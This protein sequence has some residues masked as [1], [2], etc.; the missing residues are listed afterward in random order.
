[1]IEMYSFGKIIV[2]GVRYS[3]DI[4]IIQKTVVPEWWRKNGHWVVPEDIIDIIDAEPEIIILGTGSPGMMKPG[5]DLIRLLRT[6]KIEL[7]KAPTAE[8]VTLFNR[9]TEEKKNIAA[10]FHLTC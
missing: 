9:L 4:K 7:I 1:M 5:V 6:K 10:G 8:T 2:D 3:H